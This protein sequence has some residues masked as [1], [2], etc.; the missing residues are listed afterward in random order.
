MGNT[1]IAQVWSIVLYYMA[2][3]KWLEL[4]VYYTS[5]TDRNCLLAAPSLLLL[6]SISYLRTKMVY[7]Y[8]IQ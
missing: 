1:E 2:H 3:I 6:A 7:H 5:S 4:N 8:S